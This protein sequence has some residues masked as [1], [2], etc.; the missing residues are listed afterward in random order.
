MCSSLQKALFDEE[1]HVKKL[2]QKV[3][4]LEKRNK[5]LQGRVKKVKRLL[6][7]TRKNGRHME[8]INQKLNEKLSS[9]GGQFPY[10]NSLKQDYS[11]AT[12]LKV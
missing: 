6:R 2:Q 10:A 4:A 9:T 3:A 12:Y 5:Q 7:Q 8:L 1:D 11:R